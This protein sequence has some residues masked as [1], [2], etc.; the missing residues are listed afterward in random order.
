MIVNVRITR[1][2]SKKLFQND[3]VD[4]ELRLHIAYTQRRS[5]ASEAL[6]TSLNRDLQR[7]NF[8]LV[9]ELTSTV[10]LQVIDRQTTPQQ[11]AEFQVH[12]PRIVLMITHFTYTSD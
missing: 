9:A 10:Q 3:L 2:K 8:D 4:V 6:H 12:A 5:M 11:V 1:C 7:S